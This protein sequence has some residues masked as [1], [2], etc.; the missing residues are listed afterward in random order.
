M[1]GASPSEELAELYPD[2]D[3]V[4]RDPDTGKPVSLTV[5][6]FRFIEGMKAQIT[7][8]PLIAELTSLTGDRLADDGGPDPSVIDAVLGKHAEIWIDLCGQACGRETHW[9]ARLRDEDARAMNGAMWTANGQF[10]FRRIIEHALSRRPVANLYRSLASWM[11]SP[12]PDTAATGKSA[13][14]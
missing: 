12:Q 14:A 5:R 1:S 3:L 11:R 6:E 8:Q 2:V 9:I 7:A 4:V 13:D 10:F